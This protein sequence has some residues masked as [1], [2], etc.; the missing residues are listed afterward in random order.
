VFS[1][2]Q[3][4]GAYVIYEPDRAKA[5]EVL[6]QLRA[7]GAIAFIPADRPDEIEVIGGTRSLPA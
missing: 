2:P 6:A 5:E 7:T 1:R 4:L 3:W